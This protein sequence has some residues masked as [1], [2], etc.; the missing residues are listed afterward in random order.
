MGQNMNSFFKALA[1]LIIVAIPNI[2]SA[3]AAEMSESIKAYWKE[4]N[5]TV[6]TGD[7][8]G[9]K[10]SC[11]PDAI[12]VDGLGGGSSPIA[13]AFEG[14]EQGFKDTVSGKM[15]AGVDFK[16]SRVLESETTNFSIGMYHYYTIHKD[17]ARTDQYIHF[18]SLLI[19]KDGWKMMMEYTKAKGTLEEWNAIA[20]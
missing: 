12:I 8:E 2:T 13:N 15:K 11:H 17:G 7:F 4:S 9:Y 6:S 20:D 3:K 10:A 1:I 14:W 19:Y 16:F 5:R 18:E